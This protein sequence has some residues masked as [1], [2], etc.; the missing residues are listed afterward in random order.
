MGH[1]RLLSYLYVL[2]TFPFFVFSGNFSLDSIRL[3]NDMTFKH[4]QSFIFK[5]ASN[6]NY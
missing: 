1:L 2:K 3:G 4:Y 6:N 5:A